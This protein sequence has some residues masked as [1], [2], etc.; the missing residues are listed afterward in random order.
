MEQHAEALGARVRGRERRQRPR[1]A[2]RRP[3][4]P[5]QRQRVA[6]PRLEAGGVEQPVLARRCPSCAPTTSMPPRR[7]APACPAT[8]PSNDA[9][10]RMRVS[11]TPG[12]RCRTR[13]GSQPCGAGGAP[14]STIAPSGSRPKT[15]APIAPALPARNRRRST[16]LRLLMLSRPPAP[17]LPQPRPRRHRRI[18]RA[19]SAPPESR[20][21]P[22]QQHLSADMPRLYVRGCLCHCPA[23]CIQV[24]SED[25]T[26][27]RVLSRENRPLI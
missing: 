5:V 6:A 16:D 9:F 3:V 1:L 10:S 2:E 23:P 17:T 8:V 22:V 20:P 13:P 11:L 7:G 19:E 25:E 12:S 26:L 27:T 21:G 4:R 24:G 18:R 14:C 15:A